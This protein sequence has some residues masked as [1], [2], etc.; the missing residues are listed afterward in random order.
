MQA[1]CEQNDVVSQFITQSKTIEALVCFSRNSKLME[2]Q[3]FDSTLQKKQKM[4]EE[5]LRILEQT[6][7]DTLR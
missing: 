4:S 3:K 6:L 5:P 2:D 7:V 1:I